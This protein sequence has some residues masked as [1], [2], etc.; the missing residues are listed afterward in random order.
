MH[1]TLYKPVKIPIP[2]RLCGGM[3]RIIYW[4]GKALVGLGHQVTLNVNAQSH[5]P[6]VELRAIAAAERIRARG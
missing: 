5:V 4:F 6:G 3:E 2:P 1:V